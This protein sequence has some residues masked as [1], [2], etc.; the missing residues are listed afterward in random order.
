MSVNVDDEYMMLQCKCVCLAEDYII[1]TSV[2]TLIWCQLLV[3]DVTLSCLSAFLYAQFKTAQR[4][5]TMETLVQ[6][7]LQHLQ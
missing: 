6:A 2:S 7:H 4:Q 3:T 5:V 1:A